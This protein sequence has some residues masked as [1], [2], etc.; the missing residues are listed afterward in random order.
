MSAARFDPIPLYP[1]TASRRF[2][3]EQAAREALRDALAPQPLADELL[4][5]QGRIENLEETG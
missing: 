4:R 1:S 2:A 3:R 5:D